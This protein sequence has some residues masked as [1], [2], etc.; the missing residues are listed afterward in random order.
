VRDAC[1]ERALWQL[2]R[3][4]NVRRGRRRDF[5]AR[6]PRE[7]RFHDATAWR[8]RAVPAAAARR[9]RDRARQ[10]QREALAIQ[11]SASSAPYSAFS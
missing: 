1:A 2:R 11:A 9:R 6:K 10:A 7:T 4:R 3:G 5:E 8:D